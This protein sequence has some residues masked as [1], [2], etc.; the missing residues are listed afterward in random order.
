M[1]KSFLGLP[2]LALPIVLFVGCWLL[3]TTAKSLCAQT[4][5]HVARGG[6][7]SGDVLLDSAITHLQGHLTVSADVGLHAQI[8]GQRLE[9]SGRYFQKGRGPERQIRFEMSI[10]TGDAETVMINVS[11]GRQWWRYV[12]NPRS[13][14]KLTVIDLTAVRAAVA[15]ARGRG[16]ATI[17]DD[18]ARGGVP[19]LL[20]R[21]QQNFQFG[22]ATTSGQGEASAWITRGVW[23]YQEL[24]RIVGAAANEKTTKISPQLNKRLPREV[25][26]H[27]HK[28]TLFPQRI[29]YLGADQSDET[30]DI[31][32]SKQSRHPLTLIE[33]TRININAPLDDHHF[34]RPLDMEEHDVT[35]RYLRELGIGKPRTEPASE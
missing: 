12:D 13:E 14:P 7:A 11:N 24:Q 20:T 2:K 34:Q 27:L 23:R 15:D 16:L 22:A 28:E 26:L 8:L 19:Q 33:L 35:A 29:E 10:P 9:G 32:S 4:D 30:S 25:V 6:T 31:R 18:L 21:L 1:K 17:N 5:E 3:P